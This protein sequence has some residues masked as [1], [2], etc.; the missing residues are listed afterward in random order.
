MKYLYSFFLLLFWQSLA[1][2]QVDSMSAVLRPWS[3]KLDVTRF[4]SRMPSAQVSLAYRYS[5]NIGF[6]SELNYYLAYIQRERSEPLLDDLVLSL[7]ASKPN[8]LL[9]GIMKGYFDRWNNVLYVGL[10]GAVGVANFDLERRVCVDAQL[11]PTG[12]C[13]CLQGVTRQL[14]VQKK[15]LLY[16]LRLGVDDSLS[17][18]LHFDVYVD[19]LGYQTR[20]NSTY[21]SLYHQTCDKTPDYIWRNLYYRNDLSRPKTDGLFDDLTGET[22]NISW[23]LGLK[24][25][26]V[27]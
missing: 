12:V 25:A 26:Y 14:K 23:F 8:L 9:S 16:G 5:D 24:I 19:I 7:D 15:H 20:S 2:G 13:R 21:E 22:S 17:D 3:I 1:F 10:K 27:L 4:M 6:E 18:R 11:S